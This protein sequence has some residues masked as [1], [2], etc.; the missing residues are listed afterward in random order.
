MSWMPHNATPHAKMAYASGKG[1]L[2]EQLEVLAHVGDGHRLVLAAGAQL[3]RAAAL[4]LGV[5][6]NRLVAVG[7]KGEAQRLEVV[8]T[9]GAD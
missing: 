5:V 2:R 9:R 1:M 7:G 4:A 3:R 6:D 8:S